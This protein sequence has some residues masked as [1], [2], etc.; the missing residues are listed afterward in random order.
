MRIPKNKAK[1]PNNKPL[2][3]ELSI[4]PPF[5]KDKIHNPSVKPAKKPNKVNPTRYKM[6]ESSAPSKPIA[7]EPQNK[8]ASL[9]TL[10]YPPSICIRLFSIKIFYKLENIN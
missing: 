8:T 9:F 7:N 1:P 10:G 6:T 2:P 5:F 3:K 4:K